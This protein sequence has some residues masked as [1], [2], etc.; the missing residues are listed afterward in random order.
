VHVFHSIILL[1]GEE[2]FALK[3]AILGQVC[4][5]NSVPATINTETGSQSVRSQTLCNFR[6]HW[7]SK[8]TESLH[9]VLLTDFKCNARSSGH[10]LGHLGELGKHA[11]VDLEELF[12]SRPI[13]VEHLHGADLEALVEDSINDLTSTASLDGVRFYNTASGVGKHSARLAL[14]GEP[15]GH[16]S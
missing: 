15:H 10:L 5:V 14:T 7:A 9:S 2:V 12:S 13:Q 3:R 11:C 1:D 6:V 16:L 8:V 4:A